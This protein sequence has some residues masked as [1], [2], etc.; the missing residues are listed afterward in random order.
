MVANILGI[1]AQTP[2]PTGDARGL[3]CA[4]SFTLPHFIYSGRLVDTLVVDAAANGHLPDFS[5]L[6]N[7]T[8]MWLG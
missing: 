8:H 6:C 7:H 4:N 5:A 3:I 1:E 2:A